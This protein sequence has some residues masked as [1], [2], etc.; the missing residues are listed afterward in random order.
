[1]A[2]CWSDT[3]NLWDSKVN[4][5][6]IST[7]EK[8]GFKSSLQTAEGAEI[9]QISTGPGRGPWGLPPTWNLEDEMPQNGNV[10]SLKT[11]WGSYCYGLRWEGFTH[12]RVQPANQAVMASPHGN[13]HERSS[14]A[15]VDMGHFKGQTSDKDPHQLNVSRLL[16]ALLLRVAS[17]CDDL[18]MKLALFDK[19]LLKRTFFLLF[20]LRGFISFLCFSTCGEH[21]AS[22]GSAPGRKL[23]ELKKR[24]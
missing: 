21:P 11:F 10:W 6:V 1:M 12:D 5:G 22:S 20:V 19:N 23:M 18:F 15:T 7:C 17:L 4:L 3:Q 9:N 14:F 13:M 8:R 24:K 2:W 16:W